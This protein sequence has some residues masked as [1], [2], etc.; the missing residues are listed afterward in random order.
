MERTRDRSTRNGWRGRTVAAV[1]FSM[2]SGCVPFLI[3]GPEPEETRPDVI[4]VEEIRRAVPRYL[5]WEEGARAFEGGDYLK[6]QE[7]FEAMEREAGTEDLRRKA[8]YG[9][10][11]IRLILAKDAAGFR[12]AMALWDE[13]RQSMPAEMFPED[14][15]ML[16]PLLRRVPPPLRGAGSATPGKGKAGEPGPVQKALQDKEEEIRL[17]QEDIQTKE[18]EIQTKENEILRLREQLE[19][20]EAI[21]RSIGEKKKGVSPP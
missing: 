10:A 18:E 20:L 11:C 21:H 16:A 19:A 6:A 8:R 14:P 17:R 5:S 1:A 4:V 7:I 15:R 2:F 12:K 3:R 9:L 13:W